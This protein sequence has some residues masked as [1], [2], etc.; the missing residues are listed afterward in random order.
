MLRAVTQR[1]A[2]LYMS[3]MFFYTLSRDKWTWAVLQMQNTD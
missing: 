3:L 1:D 2:G